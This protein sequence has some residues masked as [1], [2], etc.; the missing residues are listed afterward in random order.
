[1]EHGEYASRG[2]LVDLFPMGSNAPYRIDFFDD[3]VD[4]I[5]QFDPENQRSTAEITTIDLLPAHEFPTDE[6]AIE[7]FRMRW[8]ERFEARREPESIYQQVSKK[9][10]RPV[11]NIGNRCF[12]IIPRLYSIIYRPIRY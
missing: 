10:G 9:S 4:S 5:R 6:L 2:S 7:N 11:S 1:M 12:L 3:E 8:R